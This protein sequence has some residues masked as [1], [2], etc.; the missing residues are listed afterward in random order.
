MP[1]NTLA[2]SQIFQTELDKQ[3]LA[4][5]TSSWM[6][7]NAGQVKY[8]GGNTVKVPSMSLTGLK[9]Y[10][11]DNGF[12]QGAVTL[13]YE[14]LILT[15]DRGTTFHLDSQDVDET[16]FVAAA[17]NVMGEFQRVQVV[18]EIDAYRY[19]KIYALAKAAQRITGAYTPDEATILDKLE[20][21]ITSI[22][23]VVGDSVPLVI[24]M[25]T[26]VRKLLNRSDK[27]AKRL[28]VG[29]FAHGA[30]NTK[31][32]T[33]NDIPILGVPSS[34]MKTAYVFNDGQTTG[35]ETGGFKA[36]AGAKDINW[37]IMTTTAPIAV[38]KQDKVRIFT[39]DQN[40]KAD[41]WKLD[42][43]RYHDLWIPKNRLGGVW[44]NSNET[45]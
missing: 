5:A 20:D 39:P 2:Y 11:R 33:Y 10:D 35:Q 13:T 22:Q 4:T 1:I 40:Q 16:N 17:G 6:D 26:T 8:N 30:V 31:V 41:A 9:Q 3:M 23:D 38:S 36:D 29:Q 24:C 43:R 27:L 32:K 15:Q 21:D 7:A 45:V 34:R 44:V 14:D 12:K 25:A 28:D 42:Y 18:P 37:I 19:S